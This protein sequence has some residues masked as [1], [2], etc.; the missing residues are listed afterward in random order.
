[1]GKRTSVYLTGADQARL[2]ASGLPLPE[3]IRRGLGACESRLVDVADGCA[4]VNGRVI[5]AEARHI[6]FAW[7]LV[8]PSIAECGGIFDCEPCGRFTF[9]NADELAQ[10]KCDHAPGGPS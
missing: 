10:L 2:E 3:V 7:S 9:A 6:R 8:H 4:V 5:E 1:M